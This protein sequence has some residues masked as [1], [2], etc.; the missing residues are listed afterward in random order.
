MKVKIRLYHVCDLSVGRE[1]ILSD[2]MAHYI[3][4]VMRSK[5]G[6]VIGVFNGFDGE[7]ACH[8]ISL[9]KKTVHLQVLEKIKPHLPPDNITLIFAVI[10][11]T[12]LEYLLQKATE[13]GAGRLQPMLTQRTVVREMN[14]ERAKAIIIE[15]AEQ[16][17]LTA[18]P[19]I[20]P[21]RS[22]AD[23]V[24]VQTH[25]IFCDE[26]GQGENLFSYLSAGHKP[27]SIIIGPE[28][29]FSAE[30]H[31]VMMGSK[32]CHGVDLGPRIM[33]AETAVLSALSA[34]MLSLKR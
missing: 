4:S 8:I 18:L 32:G 11:K 13:L 12:P 3:S 31:S 34:C 17:G 28:G 7:Y 6:D 27:Q 19:D 20:L 10:K 33:R 30:E 1:I 5:I 22:F 14:E 16:C 26:T 9:Q 23:I 24:P 25:A 2:K 21:I 15:A 29:G